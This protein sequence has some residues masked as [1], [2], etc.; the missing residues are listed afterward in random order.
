VRLSVQNFNSRLDP[1]ESSAT[2][3]RDIGRSEAS[4]NISGNMTSPVTK[5]KMDSGI[6]SPKDDGF[7]IK[8]VDS[9]I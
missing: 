8:L 3:A 4:Q 1:K 9:K 2:N 7:G 6:S 5:Y